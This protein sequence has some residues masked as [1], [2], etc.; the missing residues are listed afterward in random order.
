[1]AKFVVFFLS[2]LTTLCF[3]PCLATMTGG[4]SRLDLKNKDNR[5][6]IMKGI[7]I[8]LEKLRKQDSPLVYRPIC[9]QASSQVVQGVL[10]RV[11]MEIAP[12]DSVFSRAIDFDCIPEAD[13][14][15]LTN[16]DKRFVC[17]S[18]WE[19][20]WLPKPE[21]FIVK[22]ENESDVQSCLMV[23]N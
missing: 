16:G 20:V 9:V 11:A 22:V 13:R 6:V 8:F 21:S 19:R 15:S 18:I 2:T 10:Y 3:T 17:F 23:N 7:G 1:M 5:D 4:I 14:P 12:E